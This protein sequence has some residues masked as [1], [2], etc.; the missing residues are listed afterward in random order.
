ME[1][2]FWGKIMFY[3]YRGK[4]TSARRKN[5]RPKSHPIFLVATLTYH[6]RL[7][8]GQRALHLVG[9]LPFWIQQDERDEFSRL[10][11]HHSLSQ[12]PAV[13]ERLL[14]QNGT[15][16]CLRRMVV[17][18]GSGSNGCYYAA[19]GFGGLGS[20]TAMCH[21]PVL[22]RRSESPGSCGHTSAGFL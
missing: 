10:I 2:K 11:C 22:R 4:K 8:L 17:E 5:H 3:S 9:V 21:L 18:N 6:F 1:D 15:I 12:V 13:I 19:G 7:F 20:C 16:H 14:N